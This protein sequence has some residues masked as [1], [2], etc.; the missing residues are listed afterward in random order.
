M[1]V[2]GDCPHEHMAAGELCLAVTA[3]HHDRVYHISLPWEKIKIQ[4]IVST[5]CMSL[6]H[7]YKVK[8]S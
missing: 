5:E 2:L 1:V 7:H 8:R 3:Q 4:S 6:F